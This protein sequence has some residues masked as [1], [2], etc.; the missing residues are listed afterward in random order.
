[1]YYKL[2]M[3]STICFITLLFVKPQYANEVKVYYLPNDDIN[4]KEWNLKKKTNIRDAIRVLYSLYS[5]TQ[6]K[7]KSELSMNLSCWVPPFRFG[8][9]YK[10]FF[11]K[12]MKM[13]HAKSQQMKI[14]YA[15]SQKLRKKANWKK[16]L[17]SIGVRDGVGGQG[18]YR[19]GRGSI[20]C[21]TTQIRFSAYQKSFYGCFFG[22]LGPKNWY[23]LI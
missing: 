16:N 3:N 13:W 23:N 10:F 17:N 21:S 15:K 20:G 9:V 6:L 11:F 12:L 18:Q 22:W 8:D 4:E 5:A 2:S 14:W 1:M 19:V 7:W